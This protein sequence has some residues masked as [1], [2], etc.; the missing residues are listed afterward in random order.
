MGNVPI[1]KPLKFKHQTGVILSKIS[2]EETS[3]IVEFMKGSKY[4]I[5]PRDM[6]ML[7]NPNLKHEVYN[8][9][10]SELS[11]MLRK[12]TDKNGVEVYKYSSIKREKHDPKKLC[13]IQTFVSA[14]K[15]G[16]ASSRDYF[17]EQ[18]G[19][20]ASNNGNSYIIKAGEKLEYA[21]IFIPPIVLDYKSEGF[22]EPIRLAE[23][24]IKNNDPII[25]KGVSG[26]TRFDLE[27]ALKRIKKE[28]EKD[29][30]TVVKDGTHRS[31]H[32]YASGTM[33]SA[34]T[35]RNQEEMP[36]NIPVDFG[37]MVIA[38]E[39]PEE[40]DRY[41]GLVHNAIAELKQLGIDS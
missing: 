1:Q 19:I 39:K 41:P 5:S 2:S 33:L 18:L 32:A 9:A 6:H 35:I 26:P 16:E 40:K 37:F 28:V 20:T 24:R 27:T 25:I 23:A 29:V 17:F 14:D 30:V 13:G 22:A 36:T 12:A 7:Y 10:D 8:I 31:Y 34:I 15:L 11:S 3:G 38:K 4:I 21:S